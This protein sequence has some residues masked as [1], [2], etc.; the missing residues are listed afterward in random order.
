MMLNTLLLDRTKWDLVLDASGNIA[1]AK[2]P[3]A[4][5]QD[6]ASA[7]QLFLGE[8]WY[9]TTQGL[10]YFENI[11]GQLPPLSLMIAL[12]EQAALTVSGVVTAQCILTSFN[13]RSVSGQIKFIDELGTSRGVNF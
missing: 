10:P 9:D 2:P 1:M 13:S 3:Y 11:L 5:E 4:L 8:L 6:V 7:I 12:I